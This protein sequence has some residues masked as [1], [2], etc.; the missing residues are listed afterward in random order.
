MKNVFKY[1]L[2]FCLVEPTPS[3]GEQSGKHIEGRSKLTGQIMSPG[4]TGQSHEDHGEIPFFS[5]D[6]ETAFGDSS[7]LGAKGMGTKDLFPNPEQIDRCKKLHFVLCS[8]SEDSEAS[9]LKNTLKTQFDGRTAYSSAAQGGDSFFLS[10]GRNLPQCVNV[11]NNRV[12]AD[13]RQLL[14]QFIYENKTYCEVG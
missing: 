9:S 4:Q 3:Y 6:E 14:S 13:L 10:L 7:I 2:N 8:K 12:V 1:F 11:Q 5:P